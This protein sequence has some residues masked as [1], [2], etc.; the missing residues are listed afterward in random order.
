ME[1]FGCKTKNIAKLLNTL[2]TNLNQVLLL[3]TI[4]FAIFWHVFVL[5]LLGLFLYSWYI[6]LHIN[7]LF[8]PLP[9]PQYPFVCLFVLFCFVL[10]VCLFV[11]CFVF[12]VNLV[13]I[14]CND[15]EINSLN[16]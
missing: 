3:I 11:F 1:F 4:N 13:L 14:V 16:P 12:A 7:G 10:F 6:F 5:C 15:I 2:E 8:W 9:S